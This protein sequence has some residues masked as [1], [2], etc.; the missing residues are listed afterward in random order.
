MP[1]APIWIDDGSPIEDTFGD[2]ERAVQWLRKLRHPKNR[3]AGNPFQLDPWQERIIRK[4]YGPRHTRDDLEAGI[5]KGDRI[6]TRVLLDIPRGNRKTTLMAAIAMLHLRGPERVP[7]TLIQSAAAA[8]KQARECFNEL[9]LIVN[10]DPRLRKSRGGMRIQD[11]RN[12]ISYP[13]ART[14]YEA[15]SADAGVQHGSTPAVV[16]ADEL[17]AWKRRDLWDVLES[18]TNKTGNTLMVIATTAGAGTDNI[19]FEQVA[20]GRKVQSG[21]IADP[22]FLPVIFEAAK[23]DDWRDPAVWHAMNPGLK[24]GYP[25]LAKLREMAARAE[26]IPAV[27]RTFQQLHLNVW[28]EYS[29]TPFV[30]IELFD[31]GKHEIDFT[32]LESDE[33]PCWLGVDLSHVDDLA[34]VVAAWRTDDGTIIVHPWFFCPQES[35][36]TRTT[37]KGTR[38]LDWANADALIPTPGVEIDLGEIERHIHDL[39]AT[40]NVREILF[41]PWHARQVQD[42]LMAANL[43]VVDHRQGYVSMSPAIFELERTLVGK[44][45]HHAGNPIL[46][47]NFENVAIQRD[48]GGNRKFNKG[49]S[50]DKID[51]AVATAMAVGRAAV[52]NDNNGLIGFGEIEDVA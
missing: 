7:G 38:Y 17:H 24:H 13:T 26:H 28:Q 14:R 35:V 4:I 33:I 2:G 37:N 30:P 40:Y 50:A 27:L 6:V 32:Q 3:A 42:G 5:R 11:T 39:C 8:R 22:A 41:D 44:R 18:A 16:I 48:P 31:A 19:C 47:W 10:F 45:L 15:I 23:N 20:Y 51:G 29:T 36:A 43:P 12:S 34:A 52:A 9:A 25:I 21:E 49:K 1:T 46:R